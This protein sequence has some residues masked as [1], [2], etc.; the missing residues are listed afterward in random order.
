MESSENT[1][2]K[3][4]ISRPT[5]GSDATST[6]TALQ[7]HDQFPYNWKNK[8]SFQTFDDSTKKNRNLARIFHGTFDQYRR[9]LEKL[10]NQG[11]GIF[12]TVN[13]TDLK[14]RRAENIVS[15]CALFIDLDTVDHERIFDYDL[16]PSLIIESSPGK[17]HVYWFCKD[18]PLGEFSS[19]QTKLADITGGDPIIKDLPRVMRFPGF[20]HQKGEKFLVRIIDNNDRV[21]TA[22]ELKQWIDKT[23]EQ[24]SNQSELQHIPSENTLGNIDDIDS[25]IN[26]LEHAQEGERNNTLNRVAYFAYGH[27]KAGRASE[28]DITERLTTTAQFIGLDQGEIEATLKSTWKKAKPVQDMFTPY[29]VGEQPHHVTR[30]KMAVCINIHEFLAKKIPEREILLSPWL[31]R[32]SISMLYAW[33]GVGKSW[34]GL[35]IGYAVSCGKQILGWNA[36]HKRRVL[37]I[38]GELPAATLQQRLR[39]IKNSYD[40]DPIE[41]GFQIITPDLQENGIMPNLADPNGRVLIN[42]HTE[43]V[44]LIIVDNL[45]TLVRG[46]KENESESWLP[47]QEWALHHRSQ[48]RSILFIHHSGKGGQQRGTSRKEDVLDTVICLRRPSDYEPSEGA[49][50]EL[51]FEKARN[52]SGDETT[53]MEVELCSENNQINWKYKPATDAIIDRVQALAEDGASR[54]EIMDET[55]FSRFQLNRLVKRANEAGTII[56]IKDGRKSTV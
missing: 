10:N 28:P 19:Y 37:Y 55:G 9:K 20:Y 5:N 41:N 2:Q 15:V 18:F 14:G 32:Q 16:P 53:P 13:Q 3:Q 42:E 51:H 46:G 8:F 17:H 33:R 39:L 40:A 22:D 43:N 36:P 34:L 11:A 47:I 48:G 44:D 49:K 6:C 30:T 54:K 45:S 52:L 35:S 25:L 7:P 26:T 24:L 21:Y 31:P 23:H 38:D 29:E 1:I 12:F 56:V 50:F 4:V 27:V